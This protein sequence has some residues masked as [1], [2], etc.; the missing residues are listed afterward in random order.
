VAALKAKTAI[1]ESQRVAEK[2]RKEN[3][4]ICSPKLFDNVNVFYYY[5]QWSDIKEK[6]KYYQK[7][8]GSKS[9]SHTGKK[10]DIQTM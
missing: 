1:E 6:S 4:I 7:Y 3:N 5:N 10:E 9:R 2:Y 8:K